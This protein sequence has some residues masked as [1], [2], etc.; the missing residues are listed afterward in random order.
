MKNYLYH[1]SLKSNVR[2]NIPI[3]LEK[4]NWKYNEKDSK[5][6]IKFPIN[7]FTWGSVMNIKIVDDSQFNV[8]IHPKLPTQIIDWGDGKRK[9]NEF[10]L[11]I[12]EIEKLN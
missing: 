7:F 11:A 2:E 5:Y 4:L 9:I 8:E 3:A 10:M 6:T 1:T 12:Q